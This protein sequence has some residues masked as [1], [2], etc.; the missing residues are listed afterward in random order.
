MNAPDTFYP[1]TL[2]QVIFEDRGD[3]E[4]EGEAPNI[5]LYATVLGCG[6]D[7]FSVEFSFEYGQERRRF[8]RFLEDLKVRDAARAAHAAELETAEL[9]REAEEEERSSDAAGPAA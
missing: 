6:A 2:I 5:C 7:G 4:V 9:S 8:R 3:G 1:G